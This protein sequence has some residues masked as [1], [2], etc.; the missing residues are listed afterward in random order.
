LVVLSAIVVS[1]WLARRNRRLGRGDLAGA[2]RLAA[3]A[4]ATNIG[5]YML[6]THY[7]ADLSAEIS[8]FLWYAGRALFLAASLWMMYMALEP[9]VRRLWPERLIGWN[10]LLAAKFTD[11]LVGRD[12]LMGAL[13]GAAFRAAH[14]A[15]FALPA[16][17]DV[18]G[19]TALP[20]SLYARNAWFLSSLGIREVD[21]IGNA[22]GAML[23]LFL[24]RVLGRRAW[25]AFLLAW[26]VVAV[27]E[28][29]ALG[30]GN[31]VLN[32]PVAMFWASLVVYLAGRHGILAVAALIS[33]ADVLHAPL[34]LSHWYAAQLLLR[35]ALV[36]AVAI[37]GFKIALAGKPV[38]GAGLLEE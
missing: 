5:S 35:T 10:R 11:P 24:A 13:A 27:I 12:L 21:A 30:E 8:S 29:G 6:R 38:F 23:I 14:C 25:L 9:F 36:L 20:V 32:V 17:W 26:I 16:L 7:V 28:L 34:D 33:C 4:L 22:L 37:Y 31:W 3:F 2:G 15:F 1:A 18:R 19:V